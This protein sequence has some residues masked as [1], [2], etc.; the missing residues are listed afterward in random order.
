MAFS[1][2]RLCTKECS[3]P[4]LDD[5]GKE[6][7]IEPGTKVVIPVY[8]LHYDEKYF[9]NPEKFDPER[10]S[11]NNI[12]FIQKFTYLPFGSGPRMCLGA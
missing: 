8:S 4:S 3:F 11:E 1:I 7:I 5:P 12:D 10:F 2:S 6:M 9:P